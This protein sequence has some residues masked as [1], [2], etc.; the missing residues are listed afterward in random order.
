MEPLLT[1]TSRALHYTFRTCFCR[2]R[3][4]EINRC[5]VQEEQTCKQTGMSIILKKHGILGENIGIKTSQHN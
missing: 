4:F 3:M 1:L 2:D 5:P